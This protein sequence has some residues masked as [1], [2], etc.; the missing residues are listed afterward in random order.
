MDVI[1]NG[2]LVQQEIA[3]R[4][5]MNEVLRDGYVEDCQ[6]AVDRGT[7]PSPRRGSRSGSSCPAVGSTAS[8]ASSPA[9]TSTPREIR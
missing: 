1:E 4:S 5:A 7:R 8:R 6:R 9:S 2:Q 3:L